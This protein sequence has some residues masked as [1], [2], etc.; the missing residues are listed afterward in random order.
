MT[1]KVLF[2]RVFG[3]GNAVMA[4][5]AIKHYRDTPGY[6]VTVVVGTTKD[7]TGALEVLRMLEG[8][9]VL[10]DRELFIESLSGWEPRDGRPT[11]RPPHMF[12]DGILSIPYDGRWNNVFNVIC[13]RVW[14]G[15]TRPDPATTGFVS[16][17]KHEAEYQLDIAE[18]LTGRP[19]IRPIDSSFYGGAADASPVVY[20]GIGYKKDRDGFWKKKHW[21]DENFLGLARMILE[22]HPGR[23]IIVTGDTE[24]MRG[25]GRLLAGLG[26][27]V[28]VSMPGL[29]QSI[30]LLAGCDS[31]IGNDTGMM[32][33]AAS[34]GK[35]VVSVFNFEGTKV[36][37]SPLCERSAVIEGHSEIPS[38]QM[39]YN[40][41]K[42]LL[43]V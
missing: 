19:A 32:H 5:P 37:N 13:E 36:K 14:D 21:G 4:I 39:V 29:V 24:D 18:H 20:F 25:T 9:R 40:V 15:R 34:M 42:D 16:W 31:Y 10:T 23:E 6:D 33:V 3:I 2:G 22:N 7:D 41:W 12:D 38:C 35:A 27:R 1:R 28:K 11:V 26:N 8:I 30:G 17:M 43:D